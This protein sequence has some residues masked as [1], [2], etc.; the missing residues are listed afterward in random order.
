MGVCN[1][2]NES[3][4]MNS[5]YTSE[6]YEPN[7]SCFSNI[8]AN[9]TAGWV[10]HALY[11]K[12]V[13]ISLAPGH[14]AGLQALAY[15]FDSLA[16]GLADHIIVG[17]SDEV[18]AHNYWKYDLI[19]FLYT[20]EKEKD[21]RLRLDNYKQKVL[22]E[23]AGMIV[24]EP[25]EIAQNRGADILGE[26]LGYGMSMDGGSFLEQNLGVEGL[27]HASS[28][29]IERSGINKEDIDLVLWAPQGNAQDKKVIDACK[30][31]LNSRYDEVPLITTTF[32]TGYIESASI[33]VTLACA[34]TALKDGNDLWP[35]LT[36]VVEID[37]K[38]LRRAPR[39]ILVLGSSDVG[40]NFA[41][42][43]KPKKQ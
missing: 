29:A 15:A 28:L 38:T 16:Q 11:L 43:I 19:D 25:L 40:Y 21:Y 14:H 13:N 2:P 41:V 33:M 18:F 36:G 5:L 1:G 6:T 37:Q 22:G 20:G 3:D 35:Q 4:H 23:G 9:S 27:L 8:T 31:L 10:S 42:V 17:A 12:G 7:I 26:V 34:L 24:M 30:R 32:N 39:N